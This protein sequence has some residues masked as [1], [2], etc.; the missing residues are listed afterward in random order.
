MAVLYVTEFANLGRD[1]NRQMLQIPELPVVAEQTVAVSGSAAASN[2]F[3][4]LTAFVMLHADT[5]CSVAFGTAP[6]AATTNLRLAA[7]TYLTLAV[8]IGASYKVSVIANT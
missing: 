8:P 5:V 7:N 6:T 3:N 4:A 2:A 1:S